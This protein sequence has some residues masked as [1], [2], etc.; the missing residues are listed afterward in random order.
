VSFSVDEGQI[1]GLIG[2]NGAGKTTTIDALC[3]FSPY[4]G[5]VL[6][7]GA[8][9]DDRAPHQRAA[10]GLARTF[11]KAG[12]CEDMT[13]EENVQVGQHRTGSAGG[14]RSME[15]ILEDLGL[16]DLRDLQ[17]SRLSQGQRQLV[18]VARALAGNPQVLLLDEPA[19]GL[20]S[21]ESLWL[22]ERLRAVR[23]GGVTILLVDHDMSLVL[24]LC[25]SID[26]LDFGALIASGSPEQIRTDERVSTAYLGATHQKLVAT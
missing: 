20:D 4:E 12:V 18:S 23:D 6:V 8:E 2:P 19:A 3:G 7:S 22:A 17:V 14:G 21:S 24:N 25:D 15:H 9:V 13:V 5:T 10:L 26:V 11:Q 16:T 1:V